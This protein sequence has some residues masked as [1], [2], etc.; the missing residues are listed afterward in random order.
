ML[1]DIR[2]ETRCHFDA[3]ASYSI[4]KLRLTPREDCGQQIKQWRVKAPAR[5]SKSSDAWGNT[6]HM[7]TLTGPHAQLSV[8]AEGRLETTEGVARIDASQSLSPLAFLA[9]TPLTTADEMLSDFAL[10]QL[11]VRGD[12]LRVVRDFMAAVTDRVRWAPEDA[13]SADNAST[14]FARGSGVARDHSHVFVAACRVAG[15]PARYVSGYRLSELDHV[16]GHA[17]A[18]VWLGAEWGW[19]SFD[20]TNN[21]LADGYLCRLAMGRDHLDA[22][23]LRGSHQGGGAEWVEEFLSVT[24]VLQKG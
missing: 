19:V 4:H 20:I 9:H 6:A 8:I 24:P 22:C 14:A 23:A 7:M 2:H 16:A 11:L 1:F 3:P 12:R 21:C 18:D 17:W 13:Q 10:E 15:M 5:C